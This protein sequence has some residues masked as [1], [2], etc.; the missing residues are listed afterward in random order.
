[1]KILKHFK[2]NK[3]TKAKLYNKLCSINLEHRHFFAKYNLFRIKFLFLFL[4]NIICFSNFS[5]A[6]IAQRGTSN[7]EAS[8]TSVT[9]QK[10][11]GVVAGDLLIVSI[12]VYDDYGVNIPTTPSGW[13]LI[14]KRF[15]ND[16]TKSAAIFYKIATASEGSSYFFHT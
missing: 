5:N 7:F 6:Q 15:L 3:I 8:S 14:D 12:S 1:M 11:T 4:I 2:M 9:L 13:N 16:G 10:P